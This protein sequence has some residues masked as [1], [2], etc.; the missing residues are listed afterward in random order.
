M[1]R[2]G[3]GAVLFAI[4]DV[5][6]SQVVVKHR[7]FRNIHDIVW[8]LYSAGQFLIALSIGEAVGLLG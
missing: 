2:L 8:L 1:F 4:S 7:G 5:L 6:L 3:I